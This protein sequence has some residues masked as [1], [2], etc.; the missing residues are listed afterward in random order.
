MIR[1]QTLKTKNAIQP[2]YLQGG[3]TSSFT[4]H[5]HLCHCLLLARGGLRLCQE[6]TN[7]DELGVLEQTP[8]LTGLTLVNPHGFKTFSPT[9]HVRPQ[10]TLRPI[11]K[12]GHSSSS[13]L[14]NF[15]LFLRR[16]TKPVPS[17]SEALKKWFEKK[18]S[19]YIFANSAGRG[20]CKPSPVVTRLKSVS[21]KVGK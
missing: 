19:S 5:L 18:K 14:K 8:C 6:G 21:H 16:V 15:L 10:N 9:Q 2:N 11:I 7:G 1:S 3:A 13:L 12:Q 17:P 20:S 4:C